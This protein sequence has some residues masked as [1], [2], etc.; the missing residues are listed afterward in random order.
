MLLP[1]TDGL[2]VSNRADHECA[3]MADKHYS[4]RTIGSAQ[5]TGP[6]SDLVL[7]DAVGS[8]L[9]VWVWHNRDGVQLDRWDH[10]TGY[11]CSLFRNESPR[12]ASEIVR[13]AEG[14]AVEKWGPN[15][16]Y[17]YVDPSKVRPSR[18]P[19]RCFI[20]AGWR[21]TRTTSAGLIMLSKQI[22]REVENP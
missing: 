12:L 22:G 18:Q 2:M 8:I 20:K 13:E 15:R 16:A 4:R 7:R 5:F 10:E 19:G 1:F 3:L 11:C 14:H 17:T 6:G 9:F 21:R